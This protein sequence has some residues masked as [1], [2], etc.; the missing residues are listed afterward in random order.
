MKVLQ[1]LEAFI[2][3][4]PEAWSYQKKNALNIHCF[5]ME[6]HDGSLGRSCGGREFIRGRIQR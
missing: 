3:L 4:Q 1:D 6:R 5:M 2:P